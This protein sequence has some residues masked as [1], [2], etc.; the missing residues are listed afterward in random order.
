MILLYGGSIY[1][2]SI[3]SKLSRGFKYLVILLSLVAFSETIS[4]VLAITVTITV[5][6]YHF[7]I[8]AQIIGYSMVFRSLIRSKG[9]VH[10]IGF[11]GLLALIISI[12][13]S[14]SGSLKAFPSSNIISLSILLI[15]STLSLFYQIVQ[16]PSQ[17]S[18][19]KLSHFWLATGTL[20]FYAGAFFIYGMFQYLLIHKHPFPTWKNGLLYTLNLI[21]YG[22]HLISIH[23]EKKPYS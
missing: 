10:T 12:Y 6:V 4:R 3:F 7:L 2:F 20:T 23:L 18:I 14:F 1:G 17:K 21:L 9:I 8:I 22:T 11:L 16:N 5:P 13:S 15:F 19:F